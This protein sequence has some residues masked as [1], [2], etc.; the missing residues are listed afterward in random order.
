MTVAELRPDVLILG[1]GK[2]GKSLARALGS[3]G[4]EVVLVERSPEMYGGT[5][6][7]VACV[8]TKAL[9]TSAE[10]RRD[11]DDPQ[12]FFDDAVAR[13]DGLTARMRARNQQLLDEVD[14]VTVIDGGARFTGPHQVEVT[15]GDERVVI[16]ADTVV[17]NTGTTPA[18]SDVPG[19]DGPRVH[20]SDSI[21]HV[22]PLPR[23]LVIVGGG[24]VGLEFAGMFS[25]FGSRVT[26]L[27]RGE[28]LLADEDDDVAAAVLESLEGIDV[29]TGIAVKGIM[30]D[31][32]RVIVGWDAGEVEADT[33]LLATGRTPVTADLG[34]DA[35]G[36]ELDQRG[37]VVVDEYLRTT[38]PGV[39]AVGDVNG[40]PQFTYV[41]YDDHRI[42][43]D[44]LR[45]AGTRRSTDRVAVPM[46]T[47]LT[48]PLARVGLTE[49]AARAEGRTIKVAARRVAD[50]AAMP[51]PKIVGEAHGL[52]KVLVDV[53][54]DQVL[55]ATW[56]GVDAQEV[57]NLM[58]VA[59]RAG[60]TATELRDG[61]YTHPSST[62]ALNEVL[63]GL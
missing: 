39:F 15:G 18:R 2:A 38:A 29:R 36:V 33:V 3:A 59:M 46:T 5:C 26:L 7:N 45:G 40:G 11:G 57:I 21:Q 8:P 54:T 10:R 49:R 63:M 41:S 4:Q 37:F 31:G 42:V 51:R 55:G 9:V 50:I 35:A 61:I 22:A 43:L 34:L 24:F 28:R 58:A 47:F 52:I 53:D 32:R 6:I 1:W 16:T 60:V 17:I 56:F 30:H 12:A 13:R 48:P 20:D 62:E 23:D 14:T 25:H 19:V 27:H 44:Q